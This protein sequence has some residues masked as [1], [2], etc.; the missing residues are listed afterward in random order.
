MV[1]PKFNIPLPNLGALGHLPVGLTGA[2]GELPKL[3]PKIAFPPGFQ[4]IS[5]LPFDGVGIS[6]GLPDVHGS[7][8]QGALGR[9]MLQGETAGQTSGLESFLLE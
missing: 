2:N 3:L 1:Q 7:S 4:L 6:L 8:P 9:R 5:P